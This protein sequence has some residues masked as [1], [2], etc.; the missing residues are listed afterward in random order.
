MR[1]H[2]QRE[3]LDSYAGAT[4][5]AERVA[6]LHRARVKVDESL[7]DLFNAARDRD[8][9]LELLRHQLAEWE[10]LALKEGELVSLMEERH[11]LTHGAKLGDA[12]RVALELIDTNE[13]SNA[14]ALAARALSQVRQVAHLDTTL[15]ESLPALEESV[16]RLR[17]VAR[18]LTRYLDKREADPSRQELVEQRLATIE[19]L[20]R[21]HRVGPEGLLSSPNGARSQHN[22]ASGDAQQRK[23]SRPTSRS[24]CRGLAWSVASFASPCRRKHQRD[25]RKPMEQRTSSSKCQPM[26]ANHRVRSPR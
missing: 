14:H 3:L 24:A 17:D 10:T 9:R 7:E 5:L 16:I 12:A 13:S 23:S 25:S 4:S 26:Q 18:D 22:L 21:K 19:S 8:S 2:A 1:S 6:E 20:A 15:A 11:R